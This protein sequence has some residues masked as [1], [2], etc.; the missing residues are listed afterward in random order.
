MDEQPMR[1]QSG[2]VVLRVGVNSFGKEADLAALAENPADAMVTSKMSECVG[3]IRFAVAMIHEH[4]PSTRI[5]LVGIFNN[6]DWSPYLKNWQSKLEQANINRGLDHF[7]NALRS[8][9]SA[10]PR[11]TFFDDRAW[12][13]RHWGQRDPET[14]QP[15]Y[16]SVQVGDF[17]SVTNTAG[18][19]PE[20]AVLANGHAGL[21]WNL[22]W[23]QELV[24]LV[25]T[26]FGIHIDAITDDEVASYVQGALNEMA[27]RDTLKP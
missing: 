8:M 25:R 14:G 26:Q 20:N 19:N 24:Q 12:F 2:V 17:M 21:V 11:L 15:N 6:A 7:D 23:T 10:D 9:A 27:R 13:G 4:H 5:V 1:W 16:R 22:L 18:D 3:Q